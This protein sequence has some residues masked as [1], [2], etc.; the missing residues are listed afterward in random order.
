MDQSAK[1]IGVLFVGCTGAVAT[2]V[3]GGVELMRKKGAPRRGM[4]SETGRVLVGETVK[5]IR[6]H[7]ALAPLDNLVF[8][9][10]DVVDRSVYDGA[11]A[12]ATMNK[13]QLASIREELAAVRPMPG[14]FSAKWLRKHPGGGGFGLQEKNLFAAAEKIRA[15]IRGF[16]EQH[17]TDRLVI[18]N[19][20]STEGYHYEK[21]AK[22]LED[23]NAFVEGLKNSDPLISPAMVYFYAAIMEGAPHVN[24]TPS[25][26]E[27]DALRIL[28]EEHKALYSGRDGK[29]GQTLLKT[30][31]APALRARQLEVAGWFSTNILGNGDGENL[32]DPDSLRTKLYSKENVLDDLLG[33]RVGGDKPSH[34]VTIHY[35]P[36]RGDSK[37]AWDNI[38]L[39]G[40]LDEPMQL[41]INFLCKD[42]IL[43]APLVIDL[44]RFSRNA[45]DRG[46]FGYFEAMSYFFK[47]PMATAR[48]RPIHDFFHQ[49][50]ILAEYLASGDHTP[51]HYPFFLY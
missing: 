20:A 44:I 49:Q 25:L 41:K 11:A 24:F 32:A 40:F 23:P 37:E 38:D 6:E 50:V 15:Q 27:V 19:L 45:A 26:A 8:G 4:L 31:I 21:G 2:T 9:G 28:A 1:K 29:T 43:A 35:Y 42:S 3:I 22:V 30:V 7:L 16:A 36:P 18:V 33:Y 34:V 17:G 51:K 13:E 46:L 47:S 10:W 5:S 39:N 48:S 14:L 12:A